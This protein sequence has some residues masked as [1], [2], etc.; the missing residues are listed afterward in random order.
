MFKDHHYLSGDISPAAK[1]YLATVNLGDVERICGFF[2]YLPLMGKKGWRR[3]HRTVVLPDFQGLGIG[4]FL[5]EWV[6]EHIYN[7]EGL[8]FCATTSSIPIIKYR[9]KRPDKWVC[10]MA[11]SQKPKSGSGKVTTSSGRITTSWKYIP[12][13]LRKHL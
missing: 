10:T 3:G 4:N 5:I 13:K 2:S 8:R 9:E 7:T 12:E 6:A 11:P 1:V